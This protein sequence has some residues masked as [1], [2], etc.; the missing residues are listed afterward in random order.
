[1]LA[2]VE[3]PKV[4]SRRFTDREMA[5]A[6]RQSHGLVTPAAEYLGVSPQT[7]YTRLK[8]SK[9][10]SAALEQARDAALDRAESKLFD[11]VEKG[12][13]WAIQF[14]LKTLGKNRGYTE[15]SEVVTEQPIVVT[16]RRVDRRSS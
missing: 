6:L 13:Q 10:V 11:A 7:I 16:L 14:V 3:Q 15:R 5:D 8:K 1:M 9:T 12:E 4:R 2:L